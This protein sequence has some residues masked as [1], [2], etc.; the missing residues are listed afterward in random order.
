MKSKHTTITITSV[1][2]LELEQDFDI[3]TY[4]LY[5]TGDFYVQEYGVGG[6]GASET[7]SANTPVF[8]QTSVQKIR[9][10]AV[11]GSV[12]VNYS[13]LG[14]IAYKLSG[15]HPDNTYLK[16][17]GSNANSDIDLDSYGIIADFGNFGDR[18]IPDIFEDMSEPTGFPNRIDSIISFDNGTRTLTISPTGD[19]FSFYEKGIKYIKTEPQSV[20]I[21]ALEGSHYIYFENGT[22]TSLDYGSIGGT[23]REIYCDTALAAIVYW[24]NT[25]EEYIYLG[26]ERHGIHMDCDTHYYEHI[27][28][29]T[30]YK[31]GLAIND[32]ISDDTG[33]SDT[34]AQ[35]SI[36]AGEIQDEDLVIAIDDDEPQNLSVPANIPVYYKI[37]TGEWRKDTATTFPVKSFIGGSGRLA[38]NEFTGGAWQQTE[39]NNL[40]LVLAHIFATNDIDNPII[41]I[42]GQATYLTATSAREGALT[43]IN[44]L[45]TTGLP[46]VEFKPI[47]TLIYQ[48]STSYSNTVK[49]RIRTT[50]M[51]EDYV[52][53]RLATA[54]SVNLIQGATAHNNL[55]GLQGG[56]AGEYYH[57]TA[58]G[59]LLGSPDTDG[60]FHGI[61]VSGVY[62]ESLAVGD[63][64]YL[65]SDGKYWKAQADADTTLPCI[66]L[67]MSA[68]NADDT[69]YILKTGYYRDDSLSLTPGGLL[70]LDTATAGLFT[71]TLPSG[72][73]EIVQIIGNA[74]SATVIY[75]KPDF[76]YVELA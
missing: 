62:G 68:G 35:V 11:T 51:G 7:I 76:T 73:G 18:I 56:Q 44:N 57:I 13:L 37:S 32:I 71:Q 22:L 58:S 28:E 43:E 53:F 29:G 20:Q 50:D 39:V 61:Y 16:L 27:H 2:W 69:G 34:H 52:D 31:S 40:S 75:F 67:V 65:D 59:L 55:S 72:S 46:F 74:I 64:V 19:S 23:L 66:G 8:K 70:Y 41:A 21:A 48:T 17:D 60:G 6:W 9:L 5:G 63:L 42:Q 33:S 30:R 1:D 54:T 3:L 4:G 38:W 14:F 26:D 15:I 25:D 36:A 49:A 10:K 12:D 45:I 24:N 47:G